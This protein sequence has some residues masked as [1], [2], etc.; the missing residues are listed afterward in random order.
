MRFLALLFLSLPIYAQFTV[1]GTIKDEANGETLIGV[2]IY[3]KEQKT[4]VSTNVYGFYSL[5]LPAGTHTLIVSYVGY[6]SLEKVINVKEDQ[7]LNIELKDKGT[8]L[9]EVVIQAEKEDANVKSV[10]MSVNKVEMRTIKKMPALLGEVDL[11][12]SILYL[13]G[14]SSVGEGSS[15]FNVRGG[16]IDQNLVLLDEAPVYN[17]SHLM[18]F[19]SIFNP[20]VVKDVKLIKGGVPAQYGGRISSILDVRMKEG[21][22]KKTEFTGGIGTIFSRLALE[23]PLKKTKDPI[24]WL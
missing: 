9:Q 15:G 8:I 3:A 19:F 24:L 1:S 12:R 20:D 21:N 13:P 6:H 18:G 14:V 22:N 4:G 17:S 2:N 23:G 5:S 7:T 16:A 10:S 11:V